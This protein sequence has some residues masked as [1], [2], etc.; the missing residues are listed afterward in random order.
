MTVSVNPVR[1]DNNDAQVLAA[2]LGVAK[3]VFR[4]AMDEKQSKRANELNKLKYDAEAKAEADKAA[5]ELTQGDLDSFVRSGGEVAA[6]GSSSPP[7]GFGRVGQMKGAPVFGRKVPQIPSGQEFNQLANLRGEYHQRSKDTDQ[8][9]NAYSRLSPQIGEKN[10]TGA[11]DMSLIYQFN[12]ILDPGSTVREGEFANAQNT[13][14]IADRAR[15]YRDQLLSGKKLSLQQRADIISESQKITKGALDNQKMIDSEYAGLSHSFG[16]DKNK[17]IDS[18]YEK[19]NKK[20]TKD[21]ED[22][23]KQFGLVGGSTGD[24]ELDAL[25]AEKARRD[26]AKG[27]ANK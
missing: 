26:K 11:S 10:P 27:T 5:G 22:A 9:V 4:V 7:P 17:I 6:I 25:M 15:V 18:R 2:A 20:L 8:I 16:L 21:I 14:G 19:L 23:A 12:K 13:A 1:S 24:P 3:D